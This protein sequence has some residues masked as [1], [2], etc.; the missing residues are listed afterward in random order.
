MNKRIYLSPPH[1]CGL[2]RDL[3]QKAFD[4]NWVAPAGPDIEA[5]EK[6]M[7]TFTSA[8]NAVALASGTA[9]LH[10]ALIVSGVN[11]N[12]DVYCSTFTF[13][14]SAFPVQYIRANPVFIDSEKDSWNMDPLLLKC[15]IEE[16]IKEKR[17][18][19]AVILVH[20]YGQSANVKEIKNICNQYGVVLIEDAAESLGSLNDN[21]HTGTVGDFGIFSFNGNKIIT[22]SGGGMLVGKRNESIDKARYLSTQAREPFPYYQHV[23]TGFNYRMSNI[24]AA[25]GRGQLSV[26]SERVNRRRK[27]YEHYQ[28]ELRSVKGI[29][30]IPR[31]TYGMSN[32]W[33]TCI[34]FDNSIGI[35]P[36]TVRLEFEKNNIETR[37]LWK[38]MHL[39]PVF[40]KNKI[41]S[42]G[43]SEKLF[44]NGLC[45]PS[46][47]SMSEDDLYRVI[48]VLKNIVN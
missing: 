48:S 5:F 20:L 14:G 44:T 37:L 3:V 30:I 22:S 38:P 18:P 1:M 43:I 28:Q 41:Y 6:E 40:I 16:T 2:E 10:L 15:A 26:L 4:S 25:I 42:N 36:E 13:A 45:L 46:G 33:L 7:C 35:S 9:A 11:V 21:Q 23:A 47:T 34:E 12:D 17:K 32:C 19:G 31:D 8:P 39:Q 24:C 29:S 27:I